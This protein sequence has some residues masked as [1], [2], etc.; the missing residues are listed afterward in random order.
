MSFRISLPA[1][2]ILLITLIG[3]S[4]EE[5]TRTEQKAMPAVAP[6]PSREQIK[7]DSLETENVSL[8]QKLVKVEQDNNT[9]NSRLTD[10]ES[11]LKAEMEKAIPA[12]PV[13]PPAQPLTTTYEAGQKAFA[14]KKY[15]DAIKIFQALLDG[16]IAE[17]Q[18]DNCHYWIGESQFG[19]KLYADAAKEFESVLQYKTSEKKGDAYFMLGRSFELQGDKAKAKEMFEKVVKDYPTSNN[20]AKAKEH[21]G[22][23]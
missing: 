16:G 11:K 20:V 15:D 17:D 9:L 7:I 23:L 3:C 14:E 2:L 22:R 18:A 19:K 21:W 8:K 1:F 13:V 10:V 6:K 12:P 5:A 4:S